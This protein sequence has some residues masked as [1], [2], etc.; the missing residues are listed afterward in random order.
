MKKL[1][2]YVCGLGY[3]SNDYITDYET[4]FGDFDTYKEAYDLFIRLLNKDN[5][6]FFIGKMSNVYKMLI[7]L[8]ECEETKNNIKCIHV[9]NE[10]WIYNPNFKE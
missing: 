5:E 9:K 7:Q 10:A 8:E 2:Y 1:R 3:D 6:S 4:D